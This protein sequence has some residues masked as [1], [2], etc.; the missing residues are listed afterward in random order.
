MHLLES[1]PLV[2]GIYSDLRV[3]RVWNILAMRGQSFRVSGLIVTLQFL[4]AAATAWAFRRE[5]SRNS[6]RLSYPYLGMFVSAARLLEVSKFPTEW[7]RS[8][9]RVLERSIMPIVVLFLRIPFTAFSQSIRWE[10]GW[11]VGEWY[12]STSATKAQPR[13]HRFGQRSS[14]PLVSTTVEHRYCWHTT[15]R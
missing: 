13:F 9:K 10:L 11:D 14:Q 12:I 15:R 6:M 5:G 4:F 2:I 8:E 3:G 7:V 1:S